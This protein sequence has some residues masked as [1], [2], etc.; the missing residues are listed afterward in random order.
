MVFLLWPQPVAWAHTAVLEVAVMQ[1]HT[2]DQ[3]VVKGHRIG[4]PDRKGEVLEAR[5]PDSSEP[6][7]VR[8]DDSGH[9]TLLF[10]GTD[11]VIEHLAQG[12]ATS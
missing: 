11:A 5:G 4:Q 9:V 3:V 10:P 8:W 7:M 12:K 6:F 2:G 1:A